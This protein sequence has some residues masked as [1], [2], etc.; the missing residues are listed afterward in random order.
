MNKYH[1]LLILILFLL[2]GMLGLTLSLYQHGFLGSKRENSTQLIQ[3]VHYPALFVKQIMGDPDAGRK[4][5]KEF[6]ASCHDK[7]PKI[8]VNAPHIGDKKAW[9]ARRQQGLSALLKIT[10]LGAGAMPARGGCF[11]CSD[12]QLSETIQYILN[13]SG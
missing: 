3:T 5:F 12:A 2:S 10:I 8:D 9:G 11:E 13:Q 7:T 4:I 1:K 6:C